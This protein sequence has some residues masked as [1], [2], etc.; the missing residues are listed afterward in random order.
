[1]LNMIASRLLANVVAK[2][3]APAGTRENSPVPTSQPSAGAPGTADGVPLNEIVNALYA[4]ILERDPEP[5]GFDACLDSLRNGTSLAAAIRGM[6][7]SDEF[8]HRLPTSLESTVVLPDLTKLYPDKYSVN[9]AGLVI[10]SAPG[11]RDFDFMESLIIKHR[12]YDSLGAWA[13]KIDLDKRVT[14]AIVQGLGASSCLELG[15]FTGPVLSLLAEQGLEVCGV[16]ISHLAFL[17]AY[18]NIHEHIRYG[19]LPDLHFDRRYDVV[20]GMDI[21]E[22]LNPLSLDTYIERIVD[23]LEPQG[24][25]YINSPMH[26]EDDVFG[27]LF[28]VYLPQWRQ[29]GNDV[30]WRQMHCDE[31]GW[32]LH[33]HLVWAHPQWW[34]S[35]FR[36]HGL[37]RDREI[38]RGMHGLLAPFFEK[39]AP[40]RRSFFLLRRAEFEPDISGTKQRLQAAIAPLV[41]ELQ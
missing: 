19:R 27:Q 20:L 36:K 29:A 22:H 38:E 4:G 7:A 37:V 16:E 14:A 24:F 28:K 3:K 17:L 33:G 31:K 8:Q 6:I 41:A 13:P 32:P 40:A 23:L 34:E 26:G 30:F 9:E 11:D 2:F 35:V 5:A 12:Y 39:Y 21:L 25:L 10:Y 1:M 18:P 15:C